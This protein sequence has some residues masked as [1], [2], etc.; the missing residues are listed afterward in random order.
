MHIIL[1]NRDCLVSSTSM[2]DLGGLAWRR[3]R[4]MSRDRSQDVDSESKTV[5]WQ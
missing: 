4:W 5:H 2:H 3:N 1:T